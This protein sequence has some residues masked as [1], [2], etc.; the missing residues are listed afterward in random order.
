[1]DKDMSIGQATNEQLH[2]EMH[3]GQRGLL[4]RFLFGRWS[5]YCFSVL[6]SRTGDLVYF[7]SDAEQDDPEVDGLP[8]V[9]LQ[10]PD[11]EFALA[12]ANRLVKEQEEAEPNC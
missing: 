5:R 3:I 2:E 11:I 12:E 8:L 7:L 4:G 9:F 6:K 10:T 1:M